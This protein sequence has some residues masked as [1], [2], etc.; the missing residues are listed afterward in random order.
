MDRSGSKSD[1]LLHLRR[2]LYRRHSVLS[3]KRLFFPP[4]AILDACKHRA[5]TSRALPCVVFFSQSVSQEGRLEKSVSI[6][7]NGRVSTSSR[8]G[9]DFYC[10]GQ[11]TESELQ[12]PSSSSSSKDGL[13][14][15][16]KRCYKLGK[17]E[18]EE[19]GSVRREKRLS[20]STVK[21]HRVLEKKYKL[22][23]LT[24]YGCDQAEPETRARDSPKKG[25]V[26]TQL[27]AI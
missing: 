14:G 2:P 18:E 4:S 3:E 10:P 8:S 7:S 15:G 21:Q 13:C 9:A 25:N 23:L 16:S 19:E 26:V 5:N 6:N 20:L 11:E 22:L 1:L 12:I 27:L 17:W 24:Q